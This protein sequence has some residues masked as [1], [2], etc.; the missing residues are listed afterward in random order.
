M[1]KED[2][3]SRNTRESPVFLTGFRRLPNSQ[4]SRQIMSEPTNPP[5]GATIASVDTVK[6]PRQMPRLLDIAVRTAMERRGVSVL[7][8]PGDIAQWKSGLG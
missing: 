3:K 6:L 2:S 8:L 4:E 1:S 7:V 5:P